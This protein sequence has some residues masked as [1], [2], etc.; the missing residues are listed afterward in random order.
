M[1]P[2]TECLEKDMLS[3]QFLRMIQKLSLYQ[4]EIM[5]KHPEVSMKEYPITD[6]LLNLIIT[7]VPFNKHTVKNE[8]LYKFDNHGQC[9]TII[10]LAISNQWNEPILTSQFI[11]NK[12]V[13]MVLHFISFISLHR[14]LSQ[15][16][17]QSFLWVQWRCQSFDLLDERREVY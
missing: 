12:W 16:H 14:R 13:Q 1:Y 5:R 6:P 11:L 17:L 7:L 15:P 2:L 8:T 3:L 4:S 10:L 9:L